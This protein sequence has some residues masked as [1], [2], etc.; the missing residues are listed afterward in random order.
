MPKRM[1]SY[2]YYLYSQK[3]T[4]FEH[5]LKMMVTHGQHNTMIEECLVTAHN[6]SDLR[7]SR[8]LSVAS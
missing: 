1:A 5:E 3:T 8:R 4:E 6:S 7:I 2:Q